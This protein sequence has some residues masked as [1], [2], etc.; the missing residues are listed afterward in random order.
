MNTF[1]SI[2]GYEDIKYELKKIADVLKSTDKYKSFG[3]S[4]P[5]GLLISGEPGVGKTLMANTL[6]YESGRKAFVCRK[7]VP[8]AE[9]TNHIS[10]V[11]EDA[12]HQA[13]S[14]VFLDDIDKY[15]N[16]DE[17]HKNDG[18]FVTIQTMIDEI[19][20]NEV[21][22][23][24]TANEPEKLPDSL[25]REGRF[26]RIIEVYAPFGDESKEIVAHYLGKIKFTDIKD[27][28]SIS[29]ILEGKSCAAIQTLVNGAG[30]IAAYESAETIA[31]EHL[32]KAVLSGFYK[33]PEYLIGK[34]RQSLEDTTEKMQRAVYHESAHAVASEILS[35][36]SVSLI[37]AYI[38]KNE[39]VAFVSS[40]AN[41]EIPRIDNMYVSIVTAL[42]GKAATRLK[43]GCNDIGV[44]KDLRSAFTTEK[45]L[46][47]YECVGGFNLRQ[48]TPA[49]VSE[50]SKAALEQIGAFE[51]E[52]LSVKATEI[53]VK[54]NDFFEK[55]AHELAVK[56]YL[57]RRD[58]DEIK[59]ACTI[60][61]VS[62]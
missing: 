5:K 20:E 47:T 58:I 53:L 48:G 3:I 16:N 42:A 19:G 50:Q 12:K 46:I 22:V 41:D 32:I 37:A 13:P 59:G 36:G 38:N 40:N 61:P 27:M 56:G 30:I 60:T 28:E 9:F 33:I 21:F 4:A 1:E 49:D 52:R 14:I 25:K 7:S 6:I 55:I 15:A 39:T 44:S 18:V 51:A 34:K 8:D 35:P 43:F 17:K 26:D 45:A 31:D 57:V 23:I 10:K 62:I 29:R 11:F 24:A 2:I 54:N